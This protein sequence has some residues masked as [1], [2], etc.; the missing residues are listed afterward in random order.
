VGWQTGELMETRDCAADSTGKQQTGFF[1][2]FGEPIKEAR[3][4]AKAPIDTRSA[5]ANRRERQTTSTRGEK[6]EDR[7]YMIFRSEIGPEFLYPVDPVK[8]HCLVHQGTLSS[9]R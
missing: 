8:T 2:P 7:I 5:G 6:S 9:H 1:D 4:Q 3:L